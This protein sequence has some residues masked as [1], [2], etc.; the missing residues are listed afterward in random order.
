MY[1]SGLQCKGPRINTGKTS[2]LPSKD[3][4]GLEFESE[5]SLSSIIKLNKL[6]HISQNYHEKEL[7]RVKRFEKQ[8]TQL[9]PEAMKYEI[10]IPLIK[11]YI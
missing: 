8:S 3:N 9:L 2:L 10:E 11:F 6:F 4:K 5:V 1:L 7:E